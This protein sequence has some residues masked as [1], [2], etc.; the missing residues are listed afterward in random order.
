[1]SL[2]VDLCQRGVRIRTKDGKVQLRS[3]A[4]GL[5]ADERAALLAERDRV[6]VVCRTLGRC[7]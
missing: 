1:M 3:P 4:G 2:I 6:L 5:S 7:N